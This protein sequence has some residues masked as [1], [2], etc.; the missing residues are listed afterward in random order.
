MVVEGNCYVTQT[1]AQLN[2]KKLDYK[3]LNCQDCKENYYFYKGKCI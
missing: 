2:C 3:T 1:L